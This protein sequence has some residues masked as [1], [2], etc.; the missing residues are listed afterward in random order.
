VFA[1]WFLAIYREPLAR[2]YVLA[3]KRYEKRKIKRKR[4]EMTVADDTNNQKQIIQ[5][6]NC[7][8]SITVDAL[9]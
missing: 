8:K 1:L 9:G 3:K 2:L 7:G 6:P 4:K 5:C